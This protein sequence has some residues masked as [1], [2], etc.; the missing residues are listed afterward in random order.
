MV[1]KQEIISE[2]L[3]EM[4][5]VLEE[6]SLYR[7]K[8]PEDLK[9]SL[10]MRWTVERGLIA[11][12]NLVFDAA[13]HILSG[14]FGVYSDTYEDT[15]Q[16]LRD[17]GVVSQSLYQKIKGLGGLRNIL[18]HDYLKVDLTELQRNLLKAFEVFPAFSSEIQQW[19]KTIA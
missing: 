6:L 2:R 7:D 15:L 17:K 18:V 4:D 1:L 16:Q 19:L 13:D 3:K 10:S 11:L 5:T 14:H 9:A 8:S 12:A